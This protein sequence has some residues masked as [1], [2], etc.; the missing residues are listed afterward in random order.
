MAGKQQQ[1]QGLPGPC[2]VWLA[3]YQDGSQSGACLRKTETCLWKGTI[4]ILKGDVASILHV[5]LCFDNL[6]R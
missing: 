5:G 3:M 4:A 2:C 6:I 1:Q